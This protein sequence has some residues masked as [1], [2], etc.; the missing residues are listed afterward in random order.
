MK[1]LVLAFLLAC[2]GEHHEASNAGE[3]AGE[4][5]E[6]MAPALKEFHDVLA[7]VWHGDARAQKACEQK[8]AF[9]DKAPATNDP[10]LIS[11]VSDLGKACVDDTS[12]VEEKLAKVHERFHAL[13]EHH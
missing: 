2:G 10:E 12:H 6:A 4:H 9:L 1:R 8:Q 7:P 5:H 3:H 11:L 13:M